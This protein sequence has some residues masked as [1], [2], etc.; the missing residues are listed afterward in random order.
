MDVTAKCTMAG[1][2][3]RVAASVQG[4]DWATASEEEDEEVISELSEEAGEEAGPAADEQSS[5]HDTPNRALGPGTRRPRSRRHCTRSAAVPS[6]MLAT[7]EPA[8]ACSL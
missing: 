5:D 3:S 2:E 8:G 4:Q 1:L 6:A 7:S